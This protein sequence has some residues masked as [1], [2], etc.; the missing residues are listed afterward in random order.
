MMLRTLAM[1]F[2][3]AVLLGCQ[4]RA[5]PKPPARSE[6]GA[7]PMN[8]AKIAVASRAFDPGEP[9]PQA[10]TGE[11]DDRSPPLEWSGVPEGAKELVLIVDDPDAP[12]DD[13]W[14]H[15]VLYGVPAGVRELPE[16]ASGQAGTLPGGA[17][18][19]RNSWPSGRT[20]GYRGP[21][22]PPGHGIHHYHFKLYALGVALEA[23]PG[24]TKDQLLQKIEGHVIGFGELVGTYVRHKE[25]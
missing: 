5:E 15:W 14:V 6:A 4:S 18:Q 1:A 19:G 25:R 16:G 21:M 11:G 3:A 20:T 10:Y 22:P 8:A 12:T 17:K 24:L 2:A 7:I 23:E 13:P 9:I